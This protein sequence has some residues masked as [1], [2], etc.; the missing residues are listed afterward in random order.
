LA[1][2]KSQKTTDDDAPFEPY[3]E[4]NQIAELH[5]ESRVDLAND[6]KS[7]GLSSDEAA[8]RLLTYGENRLTL[9]RFFPIWRRCLKE[10][11]DTFYRFSKK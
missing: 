1:E 4:L 5:P 3:L 11:Q 6:E 10:F 8:K 7:A 9:S 2:E